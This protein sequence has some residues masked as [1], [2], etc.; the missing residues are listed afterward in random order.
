MKAKTILLVISRILFMT[1]LFIIQIF[2]SNLLPVP[3]NKIN[4]ILLAMMAA[5]VF[6]IAKDFLP[7]LFGLSLLTELFHVTPF[8]FMTASL[9]VSM[10]ILEWLLV[11]VLTNRFFMIV[12][13]AGIIGVFSYRL[14][15][16][17]LSYFW[18]A[19]AEG[20][21]VIN[22]AALLGFG[23]EIIMNAS[24]LTLIYIAASLFL[25]KL[26]PR[27]VINDY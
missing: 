4:V 14:F 9:L 17:I 7:Y 19:I 6:S 24:A 15:Y 23:Q 22:S 26:N 11:N 10:F 5:L 8:G 13:I 18:R 2:I 12:F 27:Y 25:R 21:F 1:I 3:F 20:S 16:I